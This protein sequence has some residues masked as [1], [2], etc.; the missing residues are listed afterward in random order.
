M[1]TILVEPGNPGV[2]AVKRICVNDLSTF[3]TFNLFDELTGGPDTTG[4]WS[5]PLVTSGG[6]LGTV[7]VS[8]LTLA[9]SPYTFTYTVSAA[10]CPDVS[11]TVT[12]IILPLPTVS[13]STTNANVCFGRNGVVD[14]VGTPGATVTYSTGSG[15]NQVVTLKWVGHFRLKYKLSYFRYDL[16]FGQR[17]F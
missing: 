4:T 7:N 11:S 5:G 17:V 6:N 3:P 13:I 10:P 8:T 12:I 9:G 14:F 16:Y 2:D 15:P 1:Q